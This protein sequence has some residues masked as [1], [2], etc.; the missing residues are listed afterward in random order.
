MRIDLMIPVV[1]IGFIGDI[2]APSFLPHYP[3]VFMLFAVVLVPRARSLCLS[4]VRSPADASSSVRLLR[5]VGRRGF[6]C[7]G[8]GP[9]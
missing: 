7:Y 4:K 6:M 2:I 3:P 1:V 9:A 8:T 5:E